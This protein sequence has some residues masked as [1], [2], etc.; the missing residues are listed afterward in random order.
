MLVNQISVFIENKPGRV[1][2]LAEVLSKN[3]INLLTLSI[4]DTKDYGILRA[5][6]RDNEKAVKILKE[7]GFTVSCT[8]LIG[9]EV[10]DKPGGLA[11]ILKIFDDENIS[12][13]YLYSYARTSD[14]NA[15]IL[16]RVENIDNALKI[17]KKKNIK[18][19]SKVF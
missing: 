15:I 1:N 2:Q 3:G 10:E 9:V 13:E 8:D 18:L 4:A 11:S 12:I 6:T 17:L 7:E 19:I 14:T 16:F 5:I